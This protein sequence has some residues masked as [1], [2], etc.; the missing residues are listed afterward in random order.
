[1]LPRSMKTHR[2]PWLPH[3]QFLQPAVRKEAALS[4]MRLKEETIEQTVHSR[5]MGTWA[6]EGIF[7]GFGPA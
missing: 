1:M 4:L 3:R 5:R 2:N 6:A 7:L